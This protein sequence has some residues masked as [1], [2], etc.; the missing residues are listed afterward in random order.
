[1][2]VT[3]GISLVVILVDDGVVDYMESV[4]KQK[5]E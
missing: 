1:M 4:I 3:A 2:V 5:N